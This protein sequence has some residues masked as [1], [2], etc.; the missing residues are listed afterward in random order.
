MLKNKIISQANIIFFAKILLAMT[1]IVIILASY[2]GANNLMLIARGLIIPILAFLYY[3]SVKSKS[4]LYLIALLFVAISNIMFFYNTYN[5]I[6][7]GLLTF[8]LFRILILIQ[9]Y[10]LPEK[11]YFKP[12]FLGFLILSIPI[13][14]LFYVT[15]EHLG[16]IFYV[17][18]ITI[19]IN[20]LIGGISISNH[21]NFDGVSHTSLLISSMFF[22]ILSVVFIIQKFFIHIPINETIR[23][24][25]ILIAHYFYYLFLLQRE[26]EIK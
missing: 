9:V 8:L 2:F 22:A 19:Q 11:V 21:Q 12:F 18:F 4:K 3:F 26:R 16:I 23:V 14:Y 15:T 10:N 25:L 6:L 5:L 20:A 24:L 7:I 17:G 13:S 1:S